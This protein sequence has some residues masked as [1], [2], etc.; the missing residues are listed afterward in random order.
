MNE[1]KLELLVQILKTMNEVQEN[2]K[3]NREIKSPDSP[4]A[5]YGCDLAV[6]GTAHS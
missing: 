3:K 5:N 4:P 1:K 2:R 6:S